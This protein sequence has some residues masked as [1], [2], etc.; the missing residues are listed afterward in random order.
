[1]WN[2]VPRW[3]TVRTAI[4]PPTASIA[5]RCRIEPD[6]ATG[7]VRDPRRG[8]EPGRNTNARQSSSLNRR[9]RSASTSPRATACSRMRSTLM[10]APSSAQLQPHAAAFLERGE[11]QHASGRFAR[12]RARAGVLDA[13]I[14][15]VAHEVGERVP[16]RLDERAIQLGAV[17][18]RSR[19]GRACRT[20]MARRAP[21]AAGRAHTD[22]TGCM[23]V[24]MTSSWSRVVTWSS[25][26]AT[27][28]NRTRGSR[29]RSRRACA[30][31]GC[32]RQHQLA[33]QVP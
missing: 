32:A 7:D 23:R 8:G 19:A 13:V 10:P 5:A 27:A 1:M 33:D 30:A 4:E 17:A 22:E 12:A 2:V 26:C 28:P 21:V 14:D 6:A 3:A 18:A 11:P 16:E 31:A 25:R 24:R 15:R 9:A 20:P 29:A